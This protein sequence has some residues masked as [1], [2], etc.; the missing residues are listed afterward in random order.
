MRYS[1]TE[2]LEIIQV[3]HFQDKRKRLATRKM[4]PKPIRA[5]KPAPTPLPRQPRHPAPDLRTLV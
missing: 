1:I 5:V 2:K 3:E 4:R